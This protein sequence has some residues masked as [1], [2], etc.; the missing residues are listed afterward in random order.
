MKNEEHGGYLVIEKDGT[1]H[2]PTKKNGKL[3]HGLMG[4]AWAALHGGFQGNKYEGPKKAEA[5]AELKKLYKQEGMETPAEGKAF[6]GAMQFRAME[7]SVRAAAGDKP[8]E[9]EA[10]VSSEMPCRT[11]CRMGNQG[12]EAYEILDH[13]EG[14]IDRSRMADG[15]VIQDTHH[16]DQ[17]GLMDAPQIKDGKLSGSIRFGTGARSQEIAKDAAAG[18]RKNMSVGYAVDPKSYKQEGM[19]DGIPVLRAMRWTPYHAA[20]VPVPADTTVGAGRDLSD[21]EP[22]APTP[23]ITTKER[24]KTM[25]TPEEIAVDNAALASARAEGATQ[26]AAARAEI[27]AIAAQHKVPAD[28]VREFTKDGVDPAKFRAAVLDWIASNPKNQQSTDVSAMERS[29]KREYSLRKLIAFAAGKGQGGIDAGFELEVAQEL[30]KTSGRSFQGIAI[31]MGARAAL[32]VTSSSAATVQ[33]TILAQEWIDALRAKLVL[34]KLGVRVMSGL[35][36]DIA[37]PK[38]TAAGTF[39]HVTPEGTAPTESAQT[40]GQVGGSPKIGGT[41][42]DISWML[43]K[44]S[45]PDAEMI[46]R[47]DLQAVVAR[48]I[49]GGVFTGAG[50]GG[51]PSGLKLASG[52]ANPTVDGTT[53][54]WAQIRA[55]QGAIEAANANLSGTIK[56]AGHPLVGSKLATLPKASNYPLF[57]LDESEKGSFIG[58]GEYFDCTT[59]GAQ[60]LWAGDWT[61]LVVGIWD[62]ADMLVDPYTNSSSGTVRVRILCGYDVLVRNGQAFA[63]NDSVP[64]T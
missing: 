16:G 64:V 6:S 50:S 13:N 55:F 46:I 38:L 49:E 1:K 28:K 62:A 56:W 44:Q 11:Y 48:G 30:Q 53:P 59:V 63:Y 47:D 27:D 15:L 42:R 60:T 19:R 58:R 9:V 18:I 33:T 54:T 26:Y 23:T 45:T 34:P 25:K 21:P 39:Y 43:L 57:I 32:T 4:A 31:P 5:L 51:A 17:V 3:D 29:A 41:F 61:N 40:L 22:D 20:F 10:S 7:L 52:V 2:L 37:L 24:Q 35:V 12:V 8:A 14:S 36:G